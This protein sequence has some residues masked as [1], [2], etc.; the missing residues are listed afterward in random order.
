MIN[1]RKFNI[2]IKGR[3]NRT[4]KI[5]ILLFIFISTIFAVFLFNPNLQWNSW[6][7]Y[8]YINL[9]KSLASGKGFREICYPNEPLGS[10]LPFGYP[11]LL[12]ILIRLSENI[13]LLKCFSFV[14]YIANIIL[15]YYLFQKFFKVPD[16]FVFTLSLIFSLNPIVINLSHII[17]SETPFLLSLLASFIFAMKYVTHDRNTNIYLILTSIS[18]IFSWQIRSLGLAMIFAIFFYLFIKKQFSRLLHLLIFTSLALLLLL[19]IYKKYTGVRLS[20]QNYSYFS[21]LLQPEY[22]AQSIYNSF[23]FYFFIIPRS[24]FGFFY[25]TIG[26]FNLHTI[27]FFKVM[28][29]LFS[30]IVLIIIVLGY[31]DLFR[32]RNFSCFFVAFY[33]IALVFWPYY[34]ERYIFPVL[35]FIL[36]YFYSGLKLTVQ[37]I[38][39]VLNGKNFNFLMIG[40]FTTI[41]ISSAAENMYR[42]FVKNE[43]IYM[44]Y[45]NGLSSYPFEWENY[46]R[47]LEWLE[48]NIQDNSIILTRDSNLCFLITGNKSVTVE[49]SQ[50]IN[51][52]IRLI[53][54]YNVDYVIVNPYYKE[55]N[56]KFL[57]LTI[58]E[59]SNKFFQL[60]GGNENSLRIFKFNSIP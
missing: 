50:T 49:G 44:L 53:N 46:F 1:I 17:L 9:G 23:S 31:F 8:E 41:L 32:S 38:A 37:K 27:I 26:H 59:N 40:I 42:G 55:T 16:I 54:E 4:R 58:Q 24:L 30:L 29:F 60:Y 28:I 34:T 15:V 3:N 2:D 56:E 47:G 39:T 11:F 12:S 10:R 22:L 18:M 35:P 7:T 45:K 13:I 36:I 6:D 19:Q 51:D 57:F 21:H 14:S 43:N 33:L 20:L 5:S 48:K 52:V 25:D